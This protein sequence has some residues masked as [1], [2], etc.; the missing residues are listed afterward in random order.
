LTNHAKVVYFGMNLHPRHQIRPDTGDEYS[1]Q[2]AQ[3]GLELI[4]LV[5]LVIGAG[6][7]VWGLQLSGIIEI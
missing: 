4:W 6:F 3:T 2:I 7:I 1:K 5:I